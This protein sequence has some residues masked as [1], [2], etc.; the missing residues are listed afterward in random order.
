MSGMRWMCVLVF[1]S[2][3]VSTPLAQA[4]KG[5]PPQNSRKPTKED[6]RVEGDQPLP[7]SE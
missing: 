6:Q 4:G 5:S 3:V 1:T 7:R 2:A